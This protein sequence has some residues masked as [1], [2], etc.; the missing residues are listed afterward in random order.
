MFIIIRPKPSRGKCLIRVTESHPE[1]FVGIM[2]FV[3]RTF[4]VS[5]VE[6]LT[7]EYEHRG[8]QV[9]FL[10]YPFHY[11]IYVLELRPE[12]QK[13]RKMIENNRPVSDHTPKSFFYVGM[14]G[15]PV[16]TR[17]QNHL[18]GYKSCSLVTHYYAGNIFTTY[19][20]LTYSEAVSLE[21]KVAEELRDQGFWVYQK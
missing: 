16:E 18:Q 2:E 19:P 21:Q 14:T 9:R 3:E 4:V 12:V 20:N 10:G 13:E 17:V 11:S 5:R 1:D 7:R 15:L 8:M 6:E